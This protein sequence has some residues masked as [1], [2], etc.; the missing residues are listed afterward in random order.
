MQDTALKP[1][2]MLDA[3]RGFAALWVVMYHMACVIVKQHA[4]H[5]NLAA[6]PIYA[7]SLF[8]A[9]GVQM[10]FVISGYCI[11]NA[12]SKALSRNEGVKSFLA[13]RLRRIYPPCWAALA[14]AAVLSIVA[15]RLVAAGKIG[16][17]DMANN[18]VLHQK[19]I[20]FLGN[21]TLTQFIFHTQLLLVQ[22]WTLCYEAAFY[23]IVAV[24]MCLAF[25]KQG[26]LMLSALHCLTC[27]VLALLIFV[28][29]VI[30]YPWDLW[31]EFGLGI[32]VYDWLTNSKQLTPK[33]F[34]GVFGML[35]LIFVSV[36]S[37]PIG[38]MQEP[39][40]ITFLFSLMFAA[41]LVPLYRYDEHLS[42]LLPIR[43]L[44]GIGLFS[45]SLYLTHTFSIGIVNQGIK[46]FYMPESLHLLAFFIV[47]VA[48]LAFARVFYH[49]FERP[50]VGKRKTASNVVLPNS[51]PHITLPVS[52]ITEDQAV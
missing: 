47:I 33:V 39:S 43:L 1:Y 20:Y 24:A 52:A 41:L 19:T 15:V 5:H 11:A 25:I 46:K 42:R 36:H 13:A 38:S 45:Y 9:L 48:A 51:V 21:L 29:T 7:F 12:A 26:Q 34:A 8:G 10:F 40:R 49:F 35:L 27:L 23:G 30:H 28:P 22:T 32:L 17:S 50:F 16:H 18:I 14:F 3:W 44:A 31:P 4:G 37:F 6:E 2:K